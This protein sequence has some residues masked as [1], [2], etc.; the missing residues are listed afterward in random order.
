MSRNVIHRQ[1]Y[2]EEFSDEDDD[3]TYSHG[4]FNFDVDN[5]DLSFHYNNT[6]ICADG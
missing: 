4:H 3:G 1:A 6:K 2:K 5:R